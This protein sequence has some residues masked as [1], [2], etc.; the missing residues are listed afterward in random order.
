MPSLQLRVED[1]L[2]RGLKWNK[3]LDPNKKGQW[4]LSGD[5][6]STADNAKEVASTI[7][8]E[9]LEAQKLLQLAAAHRMNTDTRRAIF[10][11]IMSGEDYI[12]AFEKLLRLDLSGKQDRDIMR[13]LLECCLKEKVF[14]KYYTVLACKLCSHDKNHKFTLQYCLWDHYKELES[15][16]LVQSLN[17]ARF[18]AEMLVSFS[19]SLAVL[20]T[21][22]LSDLRRL[23]PKRTMHFRMLFEAIFEHPEATIWNIFTRAAIVPEL[24][25]VR[26]GL[27]FFIKQYVAG[28]NQSISEKFK[29]TRKAFNNVEGVLK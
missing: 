15:L 5:I 3:L 6:A 21:V 14:N 2:L 27:E 22:D 7:D 25:T 11:I 4:W 9:V 18:T 17:L 19:L 24:E 12:D 20:K 13:V 16:D 29:R 8:R 23:T 28:N 1:I 26:N 10:C